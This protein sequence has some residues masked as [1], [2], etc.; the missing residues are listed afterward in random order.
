MAELNAVRASGCDGR[1]GTRFRFENSA[2]LTEAAKRMA[3]GAPL[4]DALDQAGYRAERSAVLQLRGDPREKSIAAFAARNAC[5]NLTDPELREIGIFQ[6]SRATW[7]ILAAPFAPPADGAAD[8][9][10]ARVLE[11]VNQAR[12]RPRV[13]G[14]KP[15]AAAGRL[16]LNV[17]LSEA[18]QGHAADMA[19]HGYFAHEGR[20]GSTAAERATR[21]RYRWRSVGE[22]IA[23]GPT[24]P[25]EVVAGWTRS[26]PHCA[27]LMAP[28]FTEMGVAYSV[29]KA[30]R[31]GIYW[32]QLFGTPQ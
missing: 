22:N 26:A 15:F 5:A 16:G 28:H 30:S 27:N 13:C 25:E 32:V 10:A 8:V 7:I 20:D 19:Q 6:R 29:N 21:A 24:T 4:G 14:D 11:L 31:A 3:L 23:S 1:R 17:R 9:V 2:Q 18:S 12:A